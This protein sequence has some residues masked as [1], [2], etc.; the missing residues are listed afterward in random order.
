MFAHTFYSDHLHQ[1]FLTFEKEIEKGDFR[2]LD[3]MHHLSAGG[4]GVHT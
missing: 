1:M 3:L 4:K 2:L